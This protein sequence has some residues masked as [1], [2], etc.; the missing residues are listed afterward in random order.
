MRDRPAEIDLRVGD[1]A[2]ANGQDFRVAE[3]VAVGA[4]A[5]IGNKHLVARGDEMDEFETRNDF[6]VR[7]AAFEKDGAI[8]AVVERAGEMEILGNQWLDRGAV[9]GNPPSCDDL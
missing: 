7:P 8:N 5:L 9:L 4:A 6:A 1:L 2:L 3:P